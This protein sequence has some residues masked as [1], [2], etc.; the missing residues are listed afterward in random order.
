MKVKG[1]VFRWGLPITAHPSLYLEA[2]D[3]LVRSGLCL[4]GGLADGTRYQVRQHSVYP[5]AL[6][7]RFI[8]TH[9]CSIP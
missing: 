7:V 1:S 3:H 4:G 9:F 5:S 6:T 8:T 2:V